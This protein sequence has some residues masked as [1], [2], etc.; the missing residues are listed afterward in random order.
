MT[1]NIGSRQIQEYGHGVG[2]GSGND[3]DANNKSIIEKALKKAFSPEFLNRI[4]DVIMFH[5]LTKENIDKIIDIELVGLYK[6]VSDMGYTLVI[7][8]KA[9]AFIADKGFDSKYGARPLKR[10]IQKYLEDEMATFIIDAAVAPGD[11]IVADIDEKGEKIAI[12]IVSKQTEQEA[13]AQ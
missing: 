6:R 9:K 7:T 13:E 5:N 2:F 8:D 12:K 10:A 1:S 4:D 3:D 11:E